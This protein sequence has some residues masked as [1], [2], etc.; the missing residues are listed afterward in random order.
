MMQQPQVQ[1]QHLKVSSKA[2]ILLQNVQKAGL[3]YSTCATEL[4]RFAHVRHRE[5]SWD[6]C[7]SD[8]IN[9][10]ENNAQE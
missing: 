10:G 8:K 7:V 9:F 3:W 4:K 1:E 5:V 6:Y 2:L